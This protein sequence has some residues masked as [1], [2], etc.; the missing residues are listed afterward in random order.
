MR[1]ANA[2]AAGAALAALGAAAPAAAQSTAGNLAGISGVQIVAGITAEAP[3]REA[4]GVTDAAYQQLFIRFRAALAESGLQVPGDAALQTISPTVRAY[5]GT[6]VPAGV[7]TALLSATT[8]GVRTPAGDVVCSVGFTA[9]LDRVLPG[10]RLAPDG[11]A[12]DRRFYAW[13]SEA[14]DVAQPN[15]IG[16]RALGTAERLGRMLGQA[17]RRDN[18]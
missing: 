7:P 15:E 2:M 5:V 9:R 10:A 18:P 4:C 3:T 12:A 13:Q 6:G 11:P 14:L 17:W 16:P 8:I 1:W